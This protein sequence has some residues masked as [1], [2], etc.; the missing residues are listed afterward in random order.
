MSAMLTTATRVPAAVGLN[1]TLM[2]Q[3][4][5]AATEAPQVEAGAREKSALLAPTTL[6]P[7]ML[8]GAVPELVKVTLC[9]LL[10]VLTAWLVKVTLLE[11]SVATGAVPVPLRLTVC[12]LPAA[13]SLILMV[14]LTG[15]EVVGEKVTEMVQLPPAPSEAPHVFVSLNGGVTLIDEMAITKPPE[16]LTVTV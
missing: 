12:G 6:M 4:A 1:V 10:R 2:A 7:L 8:S 9:E 15:P 14:P 3:L 11:L 13:S 16:L 5:P